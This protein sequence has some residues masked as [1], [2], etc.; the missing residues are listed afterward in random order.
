[1]LPLLAGATPPD[2]GGGPGGAQN[3]EDNM[4]QRYCLKWNNYQSNVTSTF[5]ELLAVEDFVDITLSAE[6]GALRAHKV[7]LSACSPYFRDILKGISAWQHPVIVLKDVPLEDL[8]G[9]VEF[10]YHGEVSVDKECLTSFL[11]TAQMLRVKGLTEDSSTSASTTVKAN[12]HGSNNQM[13]TAAPSS[14]VSGGRVHSRKSS[15]PKRSLPFSSTESSAAQ[16]HPIVKK[17][18]S[19]DQ[20]NNSFQQD[21][22]IPNHM[23]V[24]P[25]QQQEPKTEYHSGNEEEID[26]VEEG[27]EVEEEINDDEDMLDGNPDDDEEEEEMSPM[28]IPNPFLGLSPQSITNAALALAAKANSNSNNQVSLDEE[29]KQ[30]QQLLLGGGD[31]M[32]SAELFASGFGYPPPLKNMLNNLNG[33]NNLTGNPG[34]IFQKPDMDIQISSASSSSVVSSGSALSQKKT[35]PYCYQ[36]LSWHALSRHIRDMHKAKSNFVTCKF[37]QKMFRNKNSLGCHMWRFHKEAKE[38]EKEPTESGGNGNKM[39]EHEFTSG[40]NVAGV[41]QPPINH[42]QPPLAVDNP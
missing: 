25:Q 10:I 34:A 5:K 1:M 13:A 28:Q 4:K 26:D 31:L 21:F 23:Q 7:V 16:Q 8:Q 29:R 9:I 24:I 2:S 42:L 6:G 35:C 22:Q 11:K 32:D 15:K 33:S 37:C 41:A 40:G 14:G 20:D 18:S 30:R 27:E 17:S 19:L 36:Q 39:L 12:N 38:K 3:H